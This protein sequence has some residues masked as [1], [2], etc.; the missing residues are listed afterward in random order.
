MKRQACVLCDA[1]TFLND[2]KGSENGDK[3]RSKERS[4]EKLVVSDLTIK[5]GYSERGK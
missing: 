4:Q 3:Y 1:F 2:R 5:E